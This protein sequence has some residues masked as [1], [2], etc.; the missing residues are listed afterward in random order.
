ML[1]M[2]N[3]KN[4]SG[5]KAFNQRRPSAG[6]QRQIYRSIGDELDVGSIIEHDAATWRV[7]RVTAIDS[8]FGEERMMD[9]GAPPFL[10]VDLGG[11]VD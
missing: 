7:L 11:P 5:K 6:H 3:D 2:N 10:L 4:L 9:E 1:N 8:P